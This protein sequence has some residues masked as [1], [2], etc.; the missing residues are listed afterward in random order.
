MLKSCPYCGRI[1]DSR[2]R[3]KQSRRKRISVDT[4]TADFRRTSKWKRKSLAIRERDNNLCRV[5]LSGEYLSNR[6]LTYDGLSVHH[7]IPVKENPDLALEDSNLITLC[8]FHHE[9]AES[10]YIPRA[11]L[12][13]L[14][15]IPPGVSGA[16]SGDD[17]DEQPGSSK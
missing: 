12:A 8:G 17:C 10:G 4:E 13:E 15:A 9:L 7:I 5:C 1:H 3:C 16:T 2:Y 11:A 6:P 14:A